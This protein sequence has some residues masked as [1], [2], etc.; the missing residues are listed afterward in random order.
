MEVEPASDYACERQCV[1]PST[2]SNMNISAT[3]GPIG[4]KLYLKHDWERGKAT[5]GFGPD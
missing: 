1:R 2:F 5:I 3:S 4:M